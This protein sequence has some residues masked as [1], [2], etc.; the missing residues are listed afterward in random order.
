MQ[1]R[2]VFF[3]LFTWLTLCGAA[4]LVLTAGDD[5]QFWLAWPLMSA[6]PFLLRPLG[7]AERLV[8]PGLTLIG[9]RRG[10]VW[11]HLAPWQPTV[12]LKACQ[13]NAFWQAVSVSTCAALRHNN[14]V[15]VSSHLL[16]TARLRRL[17]GELTG[18]GQPFRCRVFSVPFTPAARAVMQLE[19]LFRQWRWRTAFRDA[20]PVMVICRSSL[21]GRI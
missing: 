12:G 13:V 3:I 16:T 20:W 7:I 18:C 21:N 8:R 11:V 2:I 14:T 15:I 1:Q 10:R 9:R 4:G 6:L 19:I 5:A 17:Q